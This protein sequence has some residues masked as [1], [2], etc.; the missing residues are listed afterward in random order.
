MGMRIR[1]NVASLVAQR[2][3]EKNNNDLANSLERLSS[4]YRINK[5][6]D[7][8]AGLAISENL[9]GQVRGLNVAKRNAN[10]AVSLVQVAEGGMNEM[11]NILI[12][13]RELTTQSASDTLGEQER[14]F[15]NK[16]YTQL[17]DEMDRIGNASEFNGKKIFDK[18]ND[19]TQYIIQ[20]GTRGTAPELNT[21]T[22]TISLE[23]LKFDSETLGF[24]KGSEIG[25]QNVG[26]QGPTRDEI[27]EKLTTV[28][29]ALARISSERATLGAVQ[30][31]L[32]S[33][34]SNLGLSL[35]SQQTAMSRIKDVD[36]ASETANLTQAKIMT[37]SSSAVL[38]QANAAPE[39]AL[40]L[41]HG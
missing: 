18:N 28:D 38:L 5:S 3:M 30:S 41:L 36:F 34:I 32:G 11:T 10:D 35:E 23:G 21:D 22:L 8:A 16:E 2:S 15:L 13:L 33:A 40:Q 7:D 25:A 14:S 19:L 17:V 1:T 9:R 20:V 6:A 24:G 37:Q 4:G 31:R 12:R 26:D 39:M 29:T 27:A